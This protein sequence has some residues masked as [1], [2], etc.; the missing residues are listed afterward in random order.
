MAYNYVWIGGAS[1]VWTD[2]TN[3]T[4]GPSYPGINA[5]DTVTIDP[6]LN[7]PV[8]GFGA[9]I[10]VASLT[11][12]ALANLEIG[13]GGFLIVAGA[14][15]VNGTLKLAG[16]NFIGS[17]NSG[18]ALGGGYL[19]DGT[20][21]ASAVVSG[22][23]TVT[24]PITGSGLLQAAG[25][26]LTVSGFVDAGGSPITIN[27]L[28]GATASLSSP[29]GVGSASGVVNI[30]FVDDTTVNNGVFSVPYGTANQIVIGNISGFQGGDLF[31]L[32]AN[33][34]TNEDQIKAIGANTVEIYYKS[35]DGVEHDLQS[36]Y[37]SGADADQIVASSTDP[38]T[39]FIN[40]VKLTNGAVVEQLSICFMPGTMIR[41]PEGEAPVETLQRGDL[42]LTAQGEARPVV[43]V[44]RQTI[45]SRFS[46]PVRNWPIRI[47]A[48]ALA[49]NVPSRDLLVS[50]EHALLV[51]DVLV[52]AAALLNGTSIRR[53]MQVPDTFVYH[54]VE[55]EDHALVLAE[56]VP[57]ETFV[58]NV[59][60]RH[61]DNWAEHD[62]L[63]PEGRTVA[64]L[65]QP[66]VKAQRQLPASIRQAL[67]ARAAA[68]GLSEAA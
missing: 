35:T 56:N 67:A 63:Y 39:G 43:W 18:I 4:G 34:V 1:N 33:A 45:V 62:A 52:N 55:L 47:A 17:T 60:R 5:T 57:A 59:D 21:P 53:E 32:Q 40:Q 23:G 27:I 46:D 3:W 14:T 64:E 37:F 29:N 19:A 54:H 38:S 41:T 44:G 42:V 31:Q 49:D 10:S 11:V 50:P 68:L 25:G 30:T 66:R 13:N 16:G 12:D 2:S 6:G 48:G 9:P 24:C 15:T 58:D 28:D 61:F 65:P 7:Q 26:T 36:F 20:T 8:V 22:Y 51:E